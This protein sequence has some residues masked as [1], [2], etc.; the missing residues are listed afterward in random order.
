[1]SKSQ[2]KKL[3]YVVDSNGKSL[4]PTTRNR[5]VR[6]WLETGQAH[7]FGN[8]QK[9]IQFTKPVNQHI[10]PVTIGVDLGRHTGISAVDQSNNREYYSAQVER[11]YVQEVKRNKQRKMYRTQKRHRLRHRQARFDNRRKSNGWLA[12]TIQHQLDFINHEINELVNFCPLIKLFWKT[13]HL[14][15]VSSLM[16]IN[17]RLITL[18]DHNQDLPLLKN[19][20]MQ[21]KTALIQLMVNTIR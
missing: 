15:F 16:M 7:W 8:S 10:Q 3:I 12:P 9:T 5:K 17:D 13:N 4:M 18:K 21:V 11:P 19:T 2:I 20:C 14:T 1:M 6:H